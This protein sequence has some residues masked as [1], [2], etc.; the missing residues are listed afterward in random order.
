MASVCNQCHP[1][2]AP[3]M[4]SRYI[5]LIWSPNVL[6]VTAPTTMLHIVA[7]V[8]PASIFAKLRA[9]HYPLYVKSPFARSA[10]VSWRLLQL[11]CTSA[12][13]CSMLVGAT[14]YNSHNYVRYGSRL[15]ILTSCG[16]VPLCLRYR[17]PTLCALAPY[18]CRH[19]FS[20]GAA[21][22]V[23]GNH[24]QRAHPPPNVSLRLTFA[25]PLATCIA[26]I[27]S[28]LGRG[29]ADG[30]RKKRAHPPPYISHNGSPS[31]SRSPPILAA[32]ASHLGRG[33]GRGQPRKAS[34]PTTHIISPYLCFHLPFC[35]SRG[36]PTR[37][38]KRV[39]KVVGGVLK[40]KGAVV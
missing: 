9:L 4:R 11:A 22:R 2:H 35:R 7:M 5:N 21:A 8:L 23:G 26:A 25:F 18:T 34:P 16:S 19:S 28:Y 39:N 36:R 38:P 17:A 1:D 27:A 40:K 30:N 33:K 13:V 3:A 20:L 15:R 10:H 29:N 37:A 14:A 6:H 12:P 32:I 31:L 24:P